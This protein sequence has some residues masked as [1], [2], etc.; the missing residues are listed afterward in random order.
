MSFLALHCPKF[1][2]ECGEKI[3]RLKWFVWT[4]RKF[5]DECKPSFLKERLLQPLV[6]AL[7]LFVA[8]ILVGH[9]WKP[10][11]PPL[12]IQRGPTP[13]ATPSANS[14]TTV[15]DDDYYL[16]GARTKKGTPCSRRVHG[17]VRCWQHKGAKPM[18]PLDQLKV[19][20]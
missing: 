2:A 13:A 8:G 18:K 11:P 9:T 16:C 20:D 5:C 14:N 17:P 12:I 1:C 19:K 15:V 6:A 4:S 10:E 7:T 3:V